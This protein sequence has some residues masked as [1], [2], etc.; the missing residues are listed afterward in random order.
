MTVEQTRNIIDHTRIFHRRVSQYYHHLADSTQRGR[1]KLLL[2]Y[3]SEHEKRLADCLS[4]YEDSAPEKI[5]NTW[6]QTASTTDASDL[7]ADVELVP[8]M[9]V[10]E[11]VDLGI[12]LAECVLEV[13]KDLARQSEPESVRQVFTSLLNLEQKAL[14]QFVRDAGRLADL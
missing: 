2:D 4:A 1:V 8:G 13:Y 5:L 9:S 10:D 3:M 12:R 11:I 14:Q 6:F 7:I